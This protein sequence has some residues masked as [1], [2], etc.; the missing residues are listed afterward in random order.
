M[1]SEAN[2]PFGSV[3]TRLCPLRAQLISMARLMVRDFIEPEDP[4]TA[5]WGPR[6]VSALRLTTMP[7]LMP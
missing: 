5:I 2:S 7:S 1:V 3:T 4:I 6:R